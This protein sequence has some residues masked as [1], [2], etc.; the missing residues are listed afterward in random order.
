M[1]MSKRT[2]SLGG[3]L[4]VTRRDDPHGDHSTLEA[5]L[6]TSKI[7]DRVRE[8]VASAPPLSAEQ[9]DRISALLVG[10]RDA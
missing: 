2:Q 3:K 1:S 6:A 5:E 4:G 9:R 7:E 10:G 8:I